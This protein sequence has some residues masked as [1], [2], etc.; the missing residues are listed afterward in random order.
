MCQPPPPPTPDKKTF[1]P[2]PPPIPP[3]IVRLEY[4]GYWVLFEISMSKIQ[5]LANDIPIGTF[6][7]RKPFQ[8]YIPAV[9]G[10]VKLYATLG[11]LRSAEL[12]IY[13]KPGTVERVIFEYNRAWGNIY[14]TH[15]PTNQQ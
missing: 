14:F 13:V 12:N 7:F 6:K 10:H 8:L 1:P 15:I 5:I 4:S 2:A 3:G 9:N 11:G